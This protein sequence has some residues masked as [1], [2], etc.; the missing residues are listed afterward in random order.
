M[1]ENERIAAH[2]RETIINRIATREYLPGEIIPSERDLAAMYHVSRPTIRAAI[3]ELVNQRYLVRIQGKGTLVRKPDHNKVALGVLNEAKN[4]SFT[5]LVRNFGIEISNKL[6]GTGLISG[7]KYYAQ[8][9]GLSLADSIYGLHRIRLGNREPLALEFTYVP[10][11]Y[12]PDIDEYN[13][14]RISLY[15]YMNS[16]GHLPVNFQETMMMI[17]AGDK[18]RNYLQLSEDETIVNYIEIIGYDRNGTLVEYTENYSR[19]D[20]LEVRFVTEY[21]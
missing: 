19:P 5:S 1:N 17:E 3:D 9:L 15:D 2:I 8:K 21:N 16:K 11:A 7:R 6:L 10:F 13:F 20:K 12:F 14:E 18:L 4:A